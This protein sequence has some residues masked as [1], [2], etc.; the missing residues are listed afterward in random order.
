MSWREKLYD[1]LAVRNYRNDRAGV[2]KKRLIGRADT[3]P[4]R[5]PADKV[6]EDVRV[7]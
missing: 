1:E 3:R 2:D 7:Q 4:D 6:Y 5:V